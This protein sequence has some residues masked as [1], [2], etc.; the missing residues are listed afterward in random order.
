MTHPSADDVVEFDL[1][2]DDGEFD[3]DDFEAGESEFD[4]SEFEDSDGE[5]E[6]AAAPVPVVA[7]VGRP[8][9]GKST[10]VNRVLGRR[11]AVGMPGT[12]HVAPVNRTI[13]SDASLP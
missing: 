11:Q 1:E 8:N 6:A 2:E 5:D 9:V 7:V 13:E 12:L 4:E 3:A 10:L